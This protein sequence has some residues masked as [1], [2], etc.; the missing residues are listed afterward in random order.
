MI[1][2]LVSPALFHIGPVPITEPV[3]V[4]WGIM[5]ALRRA[6]LALPAACARPSSTPGGVA[7]WWSKPSTAQIRDTMR[8][9]PAPYRALHRHAVRLHLRRQLVVAGPRREPPTARL[10]TDAA[11]ALIVFFAVIWFGVRAGGLAGLS[12]DLR[13][14]EPADDPAQLRREP[15]AHLLAAGAPVRQRHERRVRRR[16][17]AVARRPA[18]ADPADGARPADRR[19][20]GLHLRRAGDGVH[21]RRGRRSRPQTPSNERTPP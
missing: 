18:R 21:R 14:A 11:L 13:H 7:S 9:D 2:P 8:V 15:D 1:S 16:H 19:G 5:A 6:A 17:R 3:V 4:T 20:A 12:R 10:E